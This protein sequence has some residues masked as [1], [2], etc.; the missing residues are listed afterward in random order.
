MGYHPGIEDDGVYLAGVKADVQP[1]LYRHDAEF[2]KLQLQ[3]TVFDRC[4]ADFVEVT[5]IPVPWAELLWQFLTLYLTLWAAHSVA[6]RLFA[7]PRA[8]WAGVAMLAA[9]F[10]V[11]VAGTAAYVADQHLHSR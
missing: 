1:D 7:E 5:R 4:V 8:Q 2:F 10:T 11:P 6:A 9:M 3:A